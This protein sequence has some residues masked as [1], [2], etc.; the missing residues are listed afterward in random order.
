MRPF[1]CLLIRLMAFNLAPFQRA[2]Q[3]GQLL[4]K[5]SERLI[6]IERIRECREGLVPIGRLLIEN[7]S[8]VNHA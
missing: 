5:A 4:H 7:S 8:V 2:A 6:H 1:G 3:A